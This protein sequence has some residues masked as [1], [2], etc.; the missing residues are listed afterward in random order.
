MEALVAT[1]T[2]VH[3]FFRWSFA[4]FHVAAAVR[5]SK[6]LLDTYALELNA[7]TSRGNLVQGIVGECRCARN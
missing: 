6:D 3:E 7:L 1:N 2:A 4:A 5:R